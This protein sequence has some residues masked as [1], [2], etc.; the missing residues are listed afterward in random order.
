MGCAI[1][2]IAQDATTHCI[3][4][5]PS[6]S[7]MSEYYEYLA[8]TYSTSKLFESIFTAPVN[9]T[10][11]NNS[12]GTMVS[13]TLIKAGVKNKIGSRN[14][15]VKEGEFKGNYIEP[16]ADRLADWLNNQWGAPEVQFQTD[17]SMT[18]KNLQDKI[19][20][21]TGVFAFKAKDR[22]AFGASGHIT[23]WD[24]TDVIKGSQYD[25]NAYANGNSG[26]VLF[27]ELK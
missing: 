24:G 7:S 9:H 27:W 14:I 6:W 26:V 21:R 4:K 16:T 11:W 15:T 25:N 13:L 17:K 3:V 23:L 1:T 12:C 22:K 18:L 19:G 5:R 20:D 2:A 10:L 8:D